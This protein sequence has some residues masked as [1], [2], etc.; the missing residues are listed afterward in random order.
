MLL[1][2]E[3]KLSKEDE[4]RYKEKNY[5]V[6]SIK[7]KPIIKAGE[8]VGI[9]LDTL[10]RKTM[11][12]INEIL[13]R[14][15]SC[16]PNTYKTNESG[17]L[18]LVIKETKNFK[19]SKLINKLTLKYKDQ[20]WHL[21]SMTDWK[22]NHQSDTDQIKTKTTYHPIYRAYL[23]RLKMYRDNRKKSKL[24]QLYKQ[25][26]V[27]V[28]VEELDNYVAAFAYLYDINVDLTNTLDKLQA[29][30]QIQFYQENEI[31]YINERVISPDDEP[32]FAGKFN[33]QYEEPIEIISF[34]NETYLDD[35][36]YNNIE[37]GET[38]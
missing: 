22:Y 35:F 11:N 9:V 5:R 8:S 6:A 7:N 14:N 4:Q 37:A 33:I 16:R 23:D 36:I 27:D 26:K 24:R 28:P 19:K 30:Q 17:D 31:P 1:I 34:G 29:Y 38:N 3:T 18:Q 13:F 32:M 10:D 12:L 2:Y 20:V 25:Y 15:D 21:T